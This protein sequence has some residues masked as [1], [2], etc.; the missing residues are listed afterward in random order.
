[1]AKV[2]KSEK[3]FSG[4]LLSV[5]RKTVQNEDGSLWEREVVSYGGSA[6]VVLAEFEGNIVLVSQFRPTAEK[7]FLELP[8]GRIEKGEQPIECAKRE[9]EEETG[10][11]ALNLRELAQFYPSPG[12]VDEKMY[13]FFADRFVKGNE[14]FDEGEELKLFTIPIDKIDEYMRGK[15]DDAKTLIGLLMWRMLKK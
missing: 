15:I 2:V 3:T 1:M 14:H 10:L 12:F 8:A 11:V 9:L 6:S 4:R 5:F 13:L 7:D